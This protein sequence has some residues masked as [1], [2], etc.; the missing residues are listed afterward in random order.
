M[1]TGITKHVT[2]EP[3]SDV[4][5]YQKRYFFGCDVVFASE[6][7]PYIHTLRLI[8][9]ILDIACGIGRK[10]RCQYYTATGD[11]YIHIRMDCDCMPCLERRVIDEEDIDDEEAEEGEEAEDHSIDRDVA[12]LSF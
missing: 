6:R 4:F 10:G 7:R 1:M 12:I 11:W 2:V 3:R 8:P 5:D 9:M